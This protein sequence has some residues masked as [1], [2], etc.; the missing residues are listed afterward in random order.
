VITEWPPQTIRAFEHYGIDYR[1]RKY[2]GTR[3]QSGGW[4]PACAKHSISN[5]FQLCDLEL[6][7]AEDIREHGFEARHCAHC[8][9]A[10]PTMLDKGSICPSC[11]RRQDRRDQKVRAEI[12]Q[13]KRGFKHSSS[14]RVP[15][16]L[17]CTER[18]PAWMAD[19]DG[20]PGHREPR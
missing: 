4:C 14:V 15:D 19:W 5:P 20:D 17:G 2:A 1:D 11:R 6:A 9:S 12:A 3:A 10:Y 13:R 16:G 18:I 8:R 7:R